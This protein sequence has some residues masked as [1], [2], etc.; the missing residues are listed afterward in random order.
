M[1]TKVAC[2]RNR[3]G[4]VRWMLFAASLVAFLSAVGQAENPRPPEPAGQNLALGKRCTLFPAPNYQLCTDPEDPLQ[5]TDGKTTKDYFWTQSGTVGWQSIGYATV[6]IDLGRL[7]PISGV[8]VTTAAGVAGVTWPMAIHLLVSEDGQ[9]YYDAGDL[10]ALDRKHAP[11]PQG[12]AIR[13][14]VTDELRTCGRYVQFVLIPL[15]GGPFLFTDEV[16]VFRG[17]EVLLASKVLR[18][19]PTTALKVYEEGRLVR[20][21]QRRWDADAAGLEELIGSTGLD[22]QAKYQARRRLQAARALRSAKVEVVSG[23][24]TVLPLGPSHAKLFQAQACLWRELGRGD[25]SVW[26]PHTWDPLELI[27]VPPA[28]GAESIRLDTVQGEYRAAAVNL[29]NSTEQ[30]LQ[31]RLR[32]QGLPESPVPSYVT[33]HEVEWTDTSQGT[34]VAAALPEARRDADSWTVTVLPGLVRQVWLTFHV[35][36]LQAGDYTGQIV[37]TSPGA[38]PQEIPVRVKVWPVKFPQQTTLWLGGW[39][40]TD[41]NTY[42][43]TP[44][45]RAAFLQHLQSH[46][47]NAPWAGSS[48]LLSFAFD[49]HDP[50]RVQLDTRRFDEWIAQ[51][52]QAQR[53]LVFLAVGDYSG[54]VKNSLGAAEI[55]S[56]EFNQRVGTWISAWVRHLQTKGLPPERLGL[57]IH[58]EPHEGSDTGPLVAWARAIRAAEPKVLIWEDPTYQD[59]AKAPAELYE[60]CD[61]LCP[62]R[63]MWLERGAPFAKFYR[64]QQSRGRTL[65]FYS[66]SGPAKL[67]DPYSY[68][69]LQAWQAWQ[70]G[71]TG[72]FFWAFG[73]NSGASSWNEYFAKAGPYTPLFL[74]ETTV[75]AGKHMEAIRESVEDFEY[76]VLLRQGVDRAKAAGRADAAVAGAERL[77][78]SAAESVLAAPGAEQLQWHRPKDRTL[79]DQTRVKILEALVA[80]QPAGVPGTR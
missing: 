35:T 21:V 66:C 69:R 65:Q 55:G 1:H 67:L 3:R 63:P 45:N 11:Y 72:S 74:D 16:E 64:E 51:W 27:A 6:T 28:P 9:T 5:L 58:D 33:L 77:L 4:L 73:D 38:A 70:V 20:A 80:L 43:V 44:Q 68:H 30:P 50:S 36:G 31:V 15:P 52:P 39:C 10:V 54:A 2:Q 40:Y 26:V 76:F 19:A 37:V 13:R 61:I 60:V 22:E 59:P 25:L 46:F 48:V 42:G 56:A 75:T 17:P 23:A 49:K 29:A 78:K 57:L 18:P 79:A 47:V 8:S 24:R 41:G 32:F 14:L 71:G 34:P 12:Y 62:N 53:Y 7:E